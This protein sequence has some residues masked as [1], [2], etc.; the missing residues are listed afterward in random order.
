MYHY[1]QE[2]S[3]SFPNLPFL[4]IDDFRKQLDYFSVQ[5]EFITKA[6]LQKLKDGGVVDGLENKILLT[7]DDGFRCHYDYVFHELVKRDLFGIFFVCTKPLFEEL[8]LD[9]HKVQILS[10]LDHVDI[11]YDHLIENFSKEVLYKN[12][13]NQSFRSE[14]YQTQKNHF[15]ITELKRILNYYV[16]E[17]A[18][19]SILDKLCE[20][21][22]IKSLGRE[23]YL[24][25]EQ[26]RDMS[27]YGMEFGNHTHSHVMLSKHDI[28][29]QNS[30]IQ[31][32]S[33]YLDE[34]GLSVE[35]FCFPHGGKR[36]YNDGTLSLLR[37]HNFK[38]ALSVEQR[39]A[40]FEDFSLN[41]FELPRFDCNQ[42]TFGQRWKL[43][44]S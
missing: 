27:E 2:Y 22:D 36:S 24:T 34:I 8:L 10:S 35:T 40:T 33:D 19:T 9:I 23:Y 16:E 4:H 18:R 1:V 29:S 15:K 28:S 32:A 21:F 42:F 41:R 14:S 31:I 5:H 13:E 43:G 12:Y 39:A 44:S 20:E 7:F 11:V 17:G 3:E 38:L 37:E 25:K 26:L 6:D 30:E